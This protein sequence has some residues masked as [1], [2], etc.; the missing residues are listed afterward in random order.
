MKRAERRPEWCAP[1]TRCYVFIGNLF[2][3]ELPV[4]AHLPPFALHSF[5]F[6]SGRRRLG[7]RIW[8]N[9][10]KFF[11]SLSVLRI[12]LCE[13]MRHCHP[14]SPAAAS[15]LSPASWLR[16]LWM[17]WQTWPLCP[18]I[19]GERWGAD[20]VWQPAGKY[21]SIPLSPFQ[22]VWTAC[23]PVNTHGIKKKKYDVVGRFE[24][25][26]LHGLFFFFIIK[27]QDKLLSDW[28]NVKWSQKTDFFFLR[29]NE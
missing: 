6:I 15:F 14:G 22:S 23:L 9:S 25:Y 10:M 7:A 11:F 2:P 17:P 4:G 12:Y 13:A 26:N 3:A 21:P 29:F 28:E 8:W 1:S 27:V 18:P 24:G 16:S 5:F 20:C 19:L